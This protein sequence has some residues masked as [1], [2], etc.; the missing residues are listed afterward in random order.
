MA[1]LLKSM[2]EKDTDAPE[3][4]P[5]PERSENYSNSTAEL[6]VELRE[7]ASAAFDQV[8]VAT[9]PAVVDRTGLYPVL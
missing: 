5:E 9:T 1:R 7:R 6:S 4:A 3:P 2:K 8:G